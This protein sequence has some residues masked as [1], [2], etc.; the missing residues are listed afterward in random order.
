MKVL[1]EL[2]SKEFLK[3]HGIKITKQKLARNKAE[4]VKFANQIKYPLVMKI[5]S[6]DIVHKTEAKGVKLNICNPKQVEKTYTELI[7]NAKKY[8]KS[9]KINGVLIQEM[10]K[11]K[12]VI[13]GTSRDP[14]F[15]PTIM[16]GLGGVFVEILKDVSFRIIPIK[17]DDAMEM[18]QETQGYKI[19]K[20]A[21]GEKSANINSLVSI[22][23]KISSLV[24]NNP[25][26]KEL[27][28]NP[29]FVDEKGA[30]AADARIIMEVK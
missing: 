1:T 23:L 10:A 17:R 6:P 8:K 24:K 28:I 19:L 3:K 11:G 4:A 7:E 18:I 5:V 29:L 25:S 20:G 9:A 12:E 22:L 2:E 21:R 14:Q 30:V 27:D 15:G 26:I 13:I 16:F